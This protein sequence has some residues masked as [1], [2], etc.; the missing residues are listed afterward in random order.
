M[1]I[2]KDDQISPKAANVHIISPCRL[3]QDAVLLVLAGALITILRYCVEPFHKGFYCDDDSIRYPY[4]HDIVS[5]TALML[6]AIMVPTAVMVVV[7]TFRL[8]IGSK[9]QSEISE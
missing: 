9:T 4:K 2:N 8:R 7:E 5:T 1:I 3:I 6:T